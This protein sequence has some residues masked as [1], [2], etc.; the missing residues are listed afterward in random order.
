MERIQRNDAAPLRMP[1]SDKFRDMG[2]I[3]GGKIES[4]TVKMNQSILIM[5]NQTKVEVIGIDVDDEPAQFARCG[6]NVLLKLRGVEEEDVSTGFVLCHP[7][8]PV[9]TT[10]F[11]DAQ[12][13]ILD[14]KNIMCAGYTAVMHVHTLVE[15]VQIADLKHLIDKKTGRKSKQPPNFVKQGQ[16]CIAR[17]EARGLICIET[18]N[19]YPQL[20]RFTIRDEG[21]TVAMGKVLKLIQDA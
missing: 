12:L 1:V 7:T 9:K 20:G 17:I 19:D 2:T 18:Y 3:V 8:A 6:D 10:R 14:F 16:I 4:G 13:I 15:E 5:P 11:F 21:K